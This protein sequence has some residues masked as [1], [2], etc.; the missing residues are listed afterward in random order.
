MVGKLFR[1]TGLI[2]KRF[3]PQLTIMVILAIY[4]MF[5]LKSSNTKFFKIEI[6]FFALSTFFLL[7][8][9]KY[10]IQNKK[11]IIFAVIS[12]LILGFLSGMFSHKIDNITELYGNKILLILL[13]SFLLMIIIP[14][15]KKERREGIDKYI[16]FL[17]KNLFFTILISIILYLGLIGIA[18]LVNYLITEMENDLY[19]Y[20]FIVVTFIFAPFLMFSFYPDNLNEIE[21]DSTKIIKFILLFILIP[22][23]SIYALVMYLYFIKILI[24]FTI[25]KGQVSQLILVY[26]L[27][28]IIII[29]LLRG[30]SI[31]KEKTRKYIERIFF[32]TELPLIA[33][34]FTA[35]FQRIEQYGMTINR[36]MILIFGVWLLIT[37]IYN[38][39]FRENKTFFT[40]LSF[41][42]FLF[43]SLNGPLSVFEYP[44]Y[45]QERRLNKILKE[46]NIDLNKNNFQNI[47]NKTK[48]EIMSI[49]DYFE[50]YDNDSLKKKGYYKGSAAEVSE[51][52][53]VSAEYDITKYYY[54]KEPNFVDIK[55]YD[56]YFELYA[57]REFKYN[58]YT[59]IISEHSE[60]YD[61]LL[62][63][64]YNNEI[65]KTINTM[66][67]KSDMI[68]MFNGEEIKNRVEIIL[69]GE[70]I[71]DLNKVDLDSENLE[72]SYIIE[73]EKVKLK[74]LI[75]YIDINNDSMKINLGINK[76]LVK[77]RY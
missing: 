5:C 1:K 51:I 29:L 38:L 50:T 21:R 47:D 15:I 61:K 76:I 22:I 42:I 58:D 14:F 63:I 26:G 71:T 44:F 3:M 60:Y 67:I 16:I 77:F 34:L 25:P 68:N 45:L 54:F 2:Y 55:D 32:I 19:A 35:I 4:L 31:I 27:V 70:K 73:D 7:V 23:L 33:L 6:L 20:L 72:I 11:Y 43:F 62:S 64:K 8:G 66:E 53:G 40:L 48:E 52:L 46:N 12:S 41:S 57:E 30:S 17:A 56:I 18:G 9:F 49:I 74:F 13:L 39:I 28:T 37:A 65:I 10:K 75:S 59:V 36:Y 24:T 69:N